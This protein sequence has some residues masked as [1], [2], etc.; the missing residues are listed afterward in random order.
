MTPT[1]TPIS[2]IFAQYHQWRFLQIINFVTDTPFCNRKIEHE[3]DPLCHGHFFWQREIWA[4]IRL[5]YASN[6]LWESTPYNTSITVSLA[7]YAT[8]I[9]DADANP[10]MYR[11]SPESCIFSN[12]LP[13]QL[14]EWLPNLCWMKYRTMAT[15]NNNG[16]KTMEYDDILVECRVIHDKQ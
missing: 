14:D 7:E 12:T 16:I 13:F 5:L 10:N 15:H 2:R 6:C 11:S 4:R 3:Y 8:V 9:K 1:P